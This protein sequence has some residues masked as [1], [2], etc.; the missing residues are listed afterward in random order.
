[1]ILLLWLYVAGLAFLIGAQ[2]NAHIE[3]AAALRGRSE[4]NSPSGSEAA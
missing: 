1:M 4:R 2:I 3:H